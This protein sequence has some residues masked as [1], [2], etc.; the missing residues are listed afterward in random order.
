VAGEGFQPA[1]LRGAIR[2]VRSESGVSERDDQT[3]VSQTVEYQNV[4]YQDN[5][6]HQA[7]LNRAMESGLADWPRDDNGGAA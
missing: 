5:A 2:I 1:P 4:V 7:G 3:V 6:D